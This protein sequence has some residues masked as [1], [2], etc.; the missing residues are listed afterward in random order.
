MASAERRASCRAAADD[1]AEAMERE[2]AED[3]VWKRIQQNT[4]TRW[5]NEHLKTANKTI[6]SLETDLADGLRLISLIEVLS[7]KKLP[8]HN[9]RPNFRSQKLE[10]VCVALKFLT[11]DE[12]IKLVNIDSSDIVDCKLKLILGLIWTLILHYSISL[13][14]W[15]G[16]DDDSAF[17]KSGPTPKQRLLRWI[18]SKLPDKPINNFTSDWNDGKAVGALVDALAPGLCPDWATWDPKNALRNAKEA[19]DLASD[20]LGVPQLVTPEEM[21]N[22]KV[23]E[24]SMMTYLAQ[25]PNAKLKEKAPLR[26]QTNPARVRC[27]GP[28]IEPT[29]VVVG[30]PTSFTVET[31]SAGQGDVEAV[32]EAPG[33]QTQ[34]VDIRYNDD[35]AKTYTATYTAMKEGPHKV[36][37]KFAGKEVPK[38]P[39]PVKVEGFA[40]DPSKAKAVGPGLQP[41]GVSAGVPTYFD[42]F[43]KDAGR[44][45]VEVEIIDP[46][47]GRNAVPCRLKKVNDDEHHCDYVPTQEGPHQ[48]QLLFA[49]RPVPGSPYKVNVGPPCNPRRVRASGR[50]LQKN[51][52]RVG[53]VADFRVFAENAGE[54]ELQVKVLGPGGVPEKVTVTAK[55]KTYDCA[56]EPTKEGRYVVMISYG[57]QEIPRSPYEVNV[58][59]YKESRI[60][61]YGPG[62]SGGLVGY[63]AAFTVDTH[64]E[65]GQLGFAIEGPSQAKIECQDNGDGSAEVKYYPT[66]PGDYAVHVLCNGEDIPKSPWIANILPQGDCAPDKVVASGPGLQPTG[67]L[68]GTPTNFTVDATQAGGKAP[69][70]VKALDSASKPVEVKVKDNGDNTYSCSYKPDSC[71][72]H[73]VQVNY[74]GVAVPGSPFRVHVADNTDPGKVRV[75]GPGVEKGV[76][77]QTPTKFYV[78][79]KAAGKA[80][81]KVK[82]TDE[83]NRD[84]KSVV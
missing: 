36:K 77:S 84:R 68:Q 1:D 18:Q 64:G 58:G 81:P 82:L 47:G 46:K 7:G 75:Y 31:F 22:P 78:D 57:G 11:N 79:C 43:T 32:V 70:E 30:A 10:N 23:D 52:V 8:K 39:F 53:D 51:G 62:L 83:Q 76:T 15:E 65:T 21:V 20:W 17:E 29:G 73:V 48:V 27:Y 59:P 35:K 5:A 55:G 50:G 71:D 3:A 37:V 13:P 49:G 9:K 4:F 60:V 69:L 42:V 16:E 38:S 40:G 12:G 34:P 61:A 26:L 14:M 33:G 54:G 24:L 63:P 2:L 67:V 72:K 19:M 6:A 44:G 80:K 41:K 56:Y 28:G 45:Q 66:A 25:F 74:A